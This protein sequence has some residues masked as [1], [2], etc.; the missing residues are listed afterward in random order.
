MKLKHLK[1][2][3][4]IDRFVFDP[5]EEYLLVYQILGVI[6]FVAFS[7]ILG[8]I[9]LVDTVKKRRNVKNKMKGGEK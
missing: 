5:R 7:I 2:S 3:S 6:L 1:A 9:F 8:L 4:R